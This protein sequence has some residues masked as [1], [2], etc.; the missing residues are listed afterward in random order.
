MAVPVLVTFRNMAT[1]DAVT[2]YAKSR[3]VAL[4]RVCDRIVNCRVTI[5]MDSRRG[6]SVFHVRIE[7]SLPGED[8]VIHRDATDH[9][10]SHEDVMLAVKGAFQ[11][12]KH[13]LQ[14][15]RRK[16]HDQPKYMGAYRSAT[17]AA[18]GT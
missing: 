12:A 7:L 10:A 11:L 5:E 8:L 14:E 1:S 15:R 17:A 9:A 4:Y 13:Q 6:T 2:E 3:A 16:E 18:K